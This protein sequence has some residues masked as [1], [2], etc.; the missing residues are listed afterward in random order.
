MSSTVQRLAADLGSFNNVP[1]EE[2]SAAITA[3]LL[4]EREAMKRLG[5]AVNETTQEWKDELKAVKAAT[6]LTGTQAKAQATLNLALR[7]SKNA[8]GDYA[9]TQG[10]LAN[11]TKAFLAD[12]EDLTVE[13]GEQFVPLAEEVVAVLRKLTGQVSK[14]LKDFT[15]DGTLA[16]KTMEGIAGAIG[17]LKDPLAGIVVGFEAAG[18]AVKAFVAGMLTGGAGVVEAVMQVGRLVELMADNA[19][20]LAKLGGKNE[21]AAFFAE[22]KAG[23]EG[24]RLQAEALTASLAKETAEAAGK[25]GAENLQKRFVEVRSIFDTVQDKASG[26]GEKFKKQAEAAGK[27]AG[28]TKETADNVKKTNDELK[29]ATQFQQISLRRFNL[30]A[31]RTKVTGGRAQQLARTA[32]SATRGEGFGS[33]NLGGAGLARENF[34]PEGGKVP[35]GTTAQERLKGLDT[36]LVQSVDEQKLVSEQMLAT[37]NGILHTLR[38]REALGLQ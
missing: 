16:Q 35:T 14:W 6:G 12:V 36:S 2:A 30:E 1:V 33:V 22:V 38:G 18:N 29:K 4:G 9:R 3:G 13:F 28:K 10:S 8:I 15:K 34:A 26:L 23:A 24:A 20:L 11:Q 19:R 21:L 25:L 17:V 37:L 32:Q 5:I 31:L 7:Q 27:T